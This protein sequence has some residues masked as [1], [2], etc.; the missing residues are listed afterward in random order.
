MLRFLSSFAEVFPH[1]QCAKAVEYLRLACAF[2]CASP[3]LCVSSVL[4]HP[5][6]VNRSFV[7]QFFLSSGVAIA[8]P[9]VCACVS[10]VVIC[11]PCHPF[12]T[13]SDASSSSPRALCDSLPHNSYTHT[14]ARTRTHTFGHRPAATGTLTLA[15]SPTPPIPQVQCGA[16][17]GATLVRIV[18]D[19]ECPIG[20]RP[21]ASQA[22]NTFECYHWDVQPTDSCS[23]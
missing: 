12:A 22:C 18:P 9:H 4:R 5:T 8:F 13:S 6:F 20:S 1:F 14:H 17:L 7:I 2:A 3:A 23:E 11:C 16:Y 19:A 21:P 10:R 15:L